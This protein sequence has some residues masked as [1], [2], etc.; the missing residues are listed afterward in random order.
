[1][2]NPEHPET[3]G[4]WSGSKFPEENN[5]WWVG[6]DCHHSGD[7]VPTSVDHIVGFNEYKDIGFVRRQID[8]LLGQLEEKEEE[9]KE[10]EKKASETKIV[11]TAKVVI[12]G[13]V[14]MEQ[15]VASIATPKNW[16]KIKL[17]S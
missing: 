10:K 13:V 14:I 16:E 2:N 7:A 1:M 17:E 4:A 15:Q 6:F 3:K 12:D 9:V 8:G 5:L 11:F